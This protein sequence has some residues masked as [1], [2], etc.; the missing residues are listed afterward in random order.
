MNE[1]VIG[2][3]PTLR[4]GILVGRRY[5]LVTGTAARRA[6]GQMELNAR[7]ANSIFITWNPLR[8]VVI[9]P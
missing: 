1:S 9:I 3:I 7:D 4:I 2:T 5:S 8:E 6:V